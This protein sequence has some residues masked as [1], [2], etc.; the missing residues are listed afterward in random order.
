MT[1]SGGGRLSMRNFFLLEG[2][3]N[4]ISLMNEIYKNNEEQ[5]NYHR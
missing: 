3:T 1:F 5:P 2:T 4:E